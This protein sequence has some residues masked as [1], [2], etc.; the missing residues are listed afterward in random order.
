MFYKKCC[1][2]ISVF[3]ALLVQPFLKSFLF[4]QQIPAYEIQEIVSGNISDIQVQAFC[5]EEIS[6]LGIFLPF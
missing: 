4:A 5:T 2:Y 3:L 6:N 1:I